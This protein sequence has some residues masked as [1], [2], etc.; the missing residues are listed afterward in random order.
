MSTVTSVCF[1]TVST[2]R[3]L[4]LVHRKRRVTRGAVLYRARLLRVATTGSV[5]TSE[6]QASVIVR[7]SEKVEVVTVVV[8]PFGVD[9]QAVERALIVFALES[10]AGN[11]SRAARLLRLTRSALIYRMHKYN[12]GEIASQRQRSATATRVIYSQG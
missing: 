7:R 12:V 9:F 8:P 2:E 3:L 4:N 5:M 6:V 1:Q 10:T 11:R